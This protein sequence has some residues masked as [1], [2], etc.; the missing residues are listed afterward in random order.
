MCAKEFL[1]LEPLAID[2]T[3]AAFVGISHDQTDT[4]E[5]LTSFRSNSGTTIPFYR[6]AGGA[7]ADQYDDLRGA[8]GG[9][10]PYPVDVVLDADGVIV[11]LAR[12]VNVDAIRDAL[13][14]GCP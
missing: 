14:A 7:A 4:D 11:Y 6:A 2:C 9:T 5:L 13:G 10:A 12:D 3:G 1:S 8:P